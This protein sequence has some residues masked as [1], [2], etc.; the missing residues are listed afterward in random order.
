MYDDESGL[1]YLNSRY[2]DPETGRF[3]NADNFLVGDSVLGMNLY[4][5]CVNNPVNLS[6]PSGCFVLT[7]SAICAIAAAA[8]ATIAFLAVAIPLTIELGNALADGLSGI[9]VLPTPIDTP[10]VDVSPSIEKE[11]TV[12]VPVP[13]ENTKTDTKTKNQPKVGY[14]Y[15]A[16]LTRPGIVVNLSSEMTYDQALQ[17]VLQGQHVWTPTESFAFTLTYFASGA[18]MLIRV[19]D[20]CPFEGP[21]EEGVRLGRNAYHYHLLNRA[22]NNVHIFWGYQAVKFI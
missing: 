22:S 12:A 11:E 15:E 3:V 4:A 19:N 20:E 2:Y 6:D 14:Y 10:T 8:A 1:Y 9:S 18:P 5:Y 21:D 17:K 13:D 16:K 7:F